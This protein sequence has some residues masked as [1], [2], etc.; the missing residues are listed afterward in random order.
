MKNKPPSKQKSEWLTLSVG[1][2]LVIGRYLT[3]GMDLFLG[4]ERL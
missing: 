1:S 2:F 3:V 4:G